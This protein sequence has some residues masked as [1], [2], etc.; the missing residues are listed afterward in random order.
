MA[1]ASRGTIVV[2][3]LRRSRRSSD[4]NVVEIRRMRWDLYVDALAA[5]Q[6][7]W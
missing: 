2:T 4:V 5:G 6:R 3:Q 7:W 1:V